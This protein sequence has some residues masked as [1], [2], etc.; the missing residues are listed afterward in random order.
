MKYGLYLHEMRA[1]KLPR[2]KNSLGISPDE[3]AEMQ[4]QI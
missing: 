2:R 3:L 1:M 4:K